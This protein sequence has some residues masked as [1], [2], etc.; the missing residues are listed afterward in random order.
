M[1]ASH[2]EPTQL[3][4]ERRYFS[5]EQVAQH[6]PQPELPIS[7]DALEQYLSAL[8]RLGRLRH[9]PN[10]SPQN[11]VFLHELLRQHQP[12]RILELGCA[13][14]YS[15][16]RLWQIARAWQAQIITMDLSRPAFDEAQHHFATLGAPIEAYFGNALELLP[17]IHARTPEN[18]DF[19]FIDAQKALTLD[20]YLRAR[21][22][23]AAGGLIVID[24]VLKFRHKMR[25][26]Y[27][28]LAEHRIA[29]HIRPLPD[30]DDGVMLIQLESF[31]SK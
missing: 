7:D 5:M 12:K 31:L 25:N 29:H 10:I 11:V 27:D 2:P 30:D 6:L 28:Y 23:A 26:F 22:L 1:S 14:G 8:Y 18:F 21:P 16:L 15:T 9:T 19:I 17:H 4:T 24:D 3:S 13:N 20:L